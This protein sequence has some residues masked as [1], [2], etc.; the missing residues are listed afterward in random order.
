MIFDFASIGFDDDEWI[1]I[2]IRYL[3]GWT[4][5]PL[6]NFSGYNIETLKFYDGFIGTLLKHTEKINEIAPAY[7]NYRFVNSWKY[8][9]KLYRVIHS[10]SDVD[11]DGNE[12]KSL[13]EIEYHGMITHWTN[14]YSFES[15]LKRISMDEEYIILEADTG[16]HFAF[17]VN[18]FRREY[19]CE[20]RYTEGERE[21]IFPMYK[22]CIKEFR[23]TI[24]EFVEKKK[25]ELEGLV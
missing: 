17:D 16:N 21:F 14:D 5:V 1:Y 4:E 20:E 2:L 11:E 12:S 25:H 15:L 18:G 8:Q 23:M 19:K 9:G 3:K 7:L 22:E 10:I 24:R 6:N 13:P